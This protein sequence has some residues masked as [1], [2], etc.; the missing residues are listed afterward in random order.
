MKREF[1][2]LM[3]NLKF[4]M[5]YSFSGRQFGIVSN[6][7]PVIKCQMDTKIYLSIEFFLLFFLFFAFLSVFLTSVTGIL[8]FFSQKIDCALM[9]VT[10][11]E[12]WKK[13]PVLTLVYVIWCFMSFSPIITKN[14][15]KKEKYS[16]YIILRQIHDDNRFSQYSELVF[17][18][19]SFSFFSFF[20]FFF[21]VF[22][23]CIHIILKFYVHIF[24]LSLTMN[25]VLS[26][27]R[28]IYKNFVT[29]WNKIAE[30]SW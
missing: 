3:N 26:K 25:F 23:F 7:N 12:K 21:V 18:P 28:N 1:T 11:K 4:S 17:L 10:K 8:F 6:T 13:L 5:Q 24:L 16:T 19:F 29:E 27:S 30:Y 2:I 20:L 22:F 15:N 9:K 14:N